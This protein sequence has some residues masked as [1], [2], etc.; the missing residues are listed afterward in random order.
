MFPVH[1]GE[2]LVCTFSSR[3]GGRGD[4]FIPGVPAALG[5]EGG[6][7]QLGSF[8][9]ENK[10]AAPV[11]NE[12]SNYFVMPGLMEFSVFVIAGLVPAIS[13]HETRQPGQARP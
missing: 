1:C 12:R 7:L 9:R 4:R 2:F 11:L 10:T 13:I 3:A 8:E 5:L 6:L